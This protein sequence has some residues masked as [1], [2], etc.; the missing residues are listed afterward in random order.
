MYWTHICDELMKLHICVS[1]AQHTTNKTRCDSCQIIH[2]KYINKQ[3]NNETH[4]LNYNSQWRSISKRILA[5]D[6]HTCHYCGHEATTVDHITPLS[7]GGTHDDWNLVAA[8][9]QCN[10]TKHNH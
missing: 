3:H 10:S 2:N 5:R 6:Q 4:K 7:R 8:C 1:C 9:R